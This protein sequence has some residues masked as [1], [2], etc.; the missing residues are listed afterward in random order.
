MKPKPIVRMVPRAVITLLFAVMV[1]AVFVPTVLMQQSGGPY[2]LNPSVIAG[3]GGTSSNGS[4]R[5]DGTVGQGILGTSTGGNFT[6]NAGFW[7]SAQAPA[8]TFN[9]SGKVTYIVPTC[10]SPSAVPVPNV[11]VTAAGTPPGGTT[12]DSSGNYTISNLTLMQP[13]TITPS[14]TPLLP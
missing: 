5:I 1:L 12:T 3:G 7:Q 11:V 9:V 14:K 6:L 10:T 4:T 2:V 13:Y 8:G